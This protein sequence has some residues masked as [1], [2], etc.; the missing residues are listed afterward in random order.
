[1]NSKIQGNDHF[2]SVT[3]RLVEEFKSWGGA[4]PFDFE[5]KLFDY[6]AW[7]IPLIYPCQ[8]ESPLK[9]V[10]Q[11]FSDFYLSRQY[12]KNI[13][14]IDVRGDV[15]LSMELP[16]RTVDVI[17]N[18]AQA[19]II[20]ILQR[21]EVLSFGQLQKSLFGHDGNT[22]PAVT[23]MKIYLKSLFTSKYPLIQS[24]STSGEISFDTLFQLNTW[25]QKE[26]LPHTIRIPITDVG[27]HLQDLQKANNNIDQFILR[28]LAEEKKLWWQELCDKVQMF[29]KEMGI[30]CEYL[31]KSRI[32][33]NIHVLLNR[34]FLK[35]EN[36]MTGRLLCT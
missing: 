27:Q 15:T 14:W 36:G 33:A 16:G 2:V 23:R 34:K 22:F 12:K 35:R 19:S 31:T 28:I 10:Q 3:V 13:N 9:E 7:S 25:D 20:L 30:D 29:S 4:T 1:M 24:D 11:S 18:P 8:L 21:H 32:S 6:C 5:V 17:L 26:E